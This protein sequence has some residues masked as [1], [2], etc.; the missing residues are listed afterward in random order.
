MILTAV[1]AGVIHTLPAV[2]NLGGEGNNGLSMFGILM[3]ETEE[4]DA[5]QSRLA[6][7]GLV[8]EEAASQS[9]EVK[10]R[11]ELY[12]KI[13]AFV[14]VGGNPAGAGK[15]DFTLHAGQGIL[16]PQKVTLTEKSGLIETYLDRGVPVI[17]FLNIKQLCLEYGISFDPAVL[18]ETGTEALY[19]ENRYSRPFILAAGLTALAAL[20]FIRRQEEKKKKDARP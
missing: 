6:E 19:F 4:I 9:E 5:M 17:Q 11:T 7:E 12:G 16:K 2:I 13:A 20:V 14:N 1:Q 3:E 10:K 8:I 15:G 18:P